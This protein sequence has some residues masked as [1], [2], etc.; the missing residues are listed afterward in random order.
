MF[1]FSGVWDARLE[2]RTVGFV[3]IFLVFMLAYI[4]ALVSGAPIAFRLFL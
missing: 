1:L 3:G 4:G 2:R